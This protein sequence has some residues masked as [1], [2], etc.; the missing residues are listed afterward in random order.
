VLEPLRQFCQALLGTSKDAL[1]D[2]STGF[3]TFEE[4][5]GVLDFAI[6]P[7]EGFLE[8]DRYW[9]ADRRVS[10]ANLIALTLIH[11]QGK[12]SPAIHFAAL[13]GTRVGR[14]AREYRRSSVSTMTNGWTG[15]SLQ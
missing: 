15:L 5:N 13:D 11:I 7:E 3:P 8:F 14:T 1:T 2:Q 6:A 4:A 10:R 12:T 9:L